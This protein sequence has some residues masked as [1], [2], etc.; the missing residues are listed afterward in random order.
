MSTGHLLPSDVGDLF[1][2]AEAICF[3]VSNEHIDLVLCLA[4][5][6]VAYN[7]SLSTETVP[8]KVRPEEPLLVLWDE[9]LVTTTIG[10]HF[11]SSLHFEPDM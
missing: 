4:L 1:Y 5:G 9:L 7:C 3:N 11:D 2:L 6:A 8:R 10:Y